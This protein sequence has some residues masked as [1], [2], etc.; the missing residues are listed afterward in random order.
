LLNSSVLFFEINRRQLIMSEG[1]AEANGSARSHDN[2]RDA[3]R[4]LIM[5]EG[6]AEAN[7]SAR[8]HDA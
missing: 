6:E 7:G 5:S 3:R 4:Q 8:S 2:K 1:E